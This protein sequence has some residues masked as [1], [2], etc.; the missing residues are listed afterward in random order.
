MAPSSYAASNL[1]PWLF[2]SYRRERPGQLQCLV[3]TLDVDRLRADAT[4]F[5]EGGPSSA[6]IM[7]LESDKDSDAT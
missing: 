2:H 4:W 5:Q 7:G 6:L 3:F 1:L